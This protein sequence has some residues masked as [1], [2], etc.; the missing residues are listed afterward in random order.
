MV[1]S[2][3]QIHDLGLEACLSRLGLGL[4]MQLQVAS[5]CSSTNQAIGSSKS[6]SRKGDRSEALRKL[7]VLAGVE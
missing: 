6:D 3:G 1:T 5:K 4:K 2:Q 7:D